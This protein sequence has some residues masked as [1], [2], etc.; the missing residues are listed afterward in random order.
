MFSGLD[1]AQKFELVGS[2]A[3]RNL[4]FYVLH[5]TASL[6]SNTFS[7]PRFQ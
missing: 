7:H 4:P 1:E 2:C 5:Q 3:L 6:R